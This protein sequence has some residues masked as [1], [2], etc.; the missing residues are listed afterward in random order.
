MHW[1]TALV[2]SALAGSMLLGA[3]SLT[4]CATPPVE[5]RPPAARAESEQ[6]ES[7]TL[8]GFTLK[9]NREFLERDPALLAQVLV[10][11]HADLNQM[12]RMVPAPAAEALRTVTVWVE[13]QGSRAMGRGGRGLCCHWSPSWLVSNGL[14]AEKVGGVEVINPSDYL[15]WLRD[16]PYMLFHEFAHAYH[17]QIAGRD[18]EIASAY[19]AAMDRGLYEAV[20]RNSVPAG[21]TV[22]AY[23]A[24]NDH[25]YFAELSEAYFA[26]NDF[27]PYTRAQLKSHDPQ[28]FAL[29]E[30]LWGLTDEE[31]ASARK[32]R[33]PG[34]GA[35]GAVK[36]PA[37]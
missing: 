34:P 30:R 13:L 5:T 26:V 15:S 16:Q 35:P 24:T 2:G 17:W 4:Q 18:G 27:Y 31:I 23:A 10:Q 8:A 1:W 29:M 22:R 12:T 37:P 6:Y 25:E 36:P 32:D 33:E 21:E 19:R 11:L 28:G 7:R 14:P 9:I 20:G 3:G